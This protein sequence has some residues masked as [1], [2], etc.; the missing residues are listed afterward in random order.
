MCTVFHT[1]RTK[2]VF[3]H[4]TWMMDVCIGPCQSPGFAYRA[5][6]QF[7]GWNH[8]CWSKTLIQS[9]WIPKSSGY[10]SQ[11]GNCILII[12]E[13][14][15]VTKFLGQYIEEK[16]GSGMASGPTNT[17]SWILPLLQVADLLENRELT[18]ISAIHCFEKV[19]LNTNAI[20]RLKWP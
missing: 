9:K 12:E 10:K 16:H 11:T 8:S 19:L 2:S 14:D 3:N 5:I 4:S 6:N 13:R 1:A 18:C 7:A 17:S 15:L 20:Q